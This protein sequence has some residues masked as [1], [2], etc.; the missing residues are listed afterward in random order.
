MDWYTG[1]FE[2]IDTRSFT[3]IWYWIVVAVTWSST[4]HYTLGVPF[5]MVTR[6]RKTEEGAAQDD[7]EHLVMINCNRMLHI[8]DV[9]GVWLVGI[10]FFVLTVLGL[11]GFFYKIQLAQAVFLL[12]APLSVVAVLSTQNARLIWTRQT[13][14]HALRAHLSR[15]R[16]INQVIGMVSIFITAF[17]GMWYNMN[18]TVL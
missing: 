14:G 7:L 1:I 16:L 3:S 2:L 18:A 12:L 4:S 11:F 13:S 6:A 15:Q 17:W 8:L 9:S 5:D 10:G